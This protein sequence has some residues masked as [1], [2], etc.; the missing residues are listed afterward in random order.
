MLADPVLVTGGYGFVGSRLSARLVADGHDVIILDNL[1]IATP[2]NLPAS[3]GGSV[4]LV[5][6][7]IRDAEVLA[8]CL[9]AH[10][11]RTVFHL[12]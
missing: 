12:A 7:D 1:S 2:A 3:V 8:R 5:E 6:A 11:P 9:T 10:R 4:R